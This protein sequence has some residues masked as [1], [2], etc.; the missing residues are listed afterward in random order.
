M[1]IFENFLGRSTLKE[2]E[3]IKNQ[4]QSLQLI[5][6]HMGED[7]NIMDFGAHAP[8]KKFHNKK[9]VYKFTIK[10]MS[11][12]F[13]AKLGQDRRVK[14]VFFASR[15]AHPG[16]GADTISLRHKIIIEYH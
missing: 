8:Y 6:E 16:G 2:E 10:L 1:S 5:K 9:N 15:H 13:L 4:D 3:K 7:L 11:L 14:N 12:S